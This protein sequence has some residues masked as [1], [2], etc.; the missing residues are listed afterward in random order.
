MLEVLSKAF[1]ISSLV[2][3]VK[4]LVS[5]GGCGW[6]IGSALVSLF[7]NQEFARSFALSLDSDTQI[8]NLGS[9]DGSLRVG[10]VVLRTPLYH[11]LSLQRSVPG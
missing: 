8:G 9:E 7:G 11:E 5:D 3:V 2:T 4:F 10:T 6:A 1:L